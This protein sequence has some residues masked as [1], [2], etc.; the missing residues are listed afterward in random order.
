MK[1]QMVL[2]GEYELVV[3]KKREKRRSQ[4]SRKGRYEVSR[5]QAKSSV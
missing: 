4:Q 5:V 1:K 3:K 2:V